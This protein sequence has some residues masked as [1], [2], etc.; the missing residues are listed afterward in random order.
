[1][2]FDEGSE[3]EV[4]E[5]VGEESPHVCVAVLPEALVVEAV[6]LRDL[7]RFMV[8]AEDCYSIAISEL[9]GYEEGDGLDGVVASVDVISHEEV[10]CVG[11]VPADAE[12]F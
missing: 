7:P 1:M 8:S 3:G 12:E 10:V 5:K 9:E 2:V 4:V 6:H 11:R